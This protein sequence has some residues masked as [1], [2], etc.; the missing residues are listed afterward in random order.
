MNDNI[1]R[2]RDAKMLADAL[3]RSASGT[4]EHE[5]VLRIRRSF[6]EWGT[7]TAAMRHALNPGITAISS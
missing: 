5:F 6:R 7:L 4:R 2:M 3:R 1:T